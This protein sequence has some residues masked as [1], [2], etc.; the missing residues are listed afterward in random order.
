MP[1][2]VLPFSLP[3]SDFP[4]LSLANSADTTSVCTPSI[5]CPNS[6]SIASPSVLPL[7]SSPVP[8]SDYPLRKSS[9]SH[10]PLSYLQDY[11]CNSISKPIASGP[12]DIAHHISNAH[13][14]TSHRSFVLASSST[15]ELESFHQAVQ[16][17]DWRAAMDKEITAL[18]SNSHLG[19]CYF[20]LWQGTYWLQM[21]LLDQIQSRW[22][23][24][25]V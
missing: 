15:T 23:S 25:K 4:L 19:C 11:S 20:T 13:L 17:S 21:D 6:G 2:S 16:S 18:E 10:K 8:P 7:A 24:G 9:R 5:E 3:D 22:L 14:S 12:Y 1:T